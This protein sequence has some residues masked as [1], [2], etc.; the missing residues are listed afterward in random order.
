MKNEA[1]GPRY[2]GASRWGEWLSHTHIL[3]LI[4]VYLLFRG[5]PSGSDGKESACNL[6]DLDLIP[7]SGRSPGEGNGYPLQY[8]CWRIPWTEEPG[9]L[10]SIEWQGVGHDYMTN[11]FGFTYFCQDDWKNSKWW[12]L[13]LP[14]S[15]SDHYEQSSPA[16]LWKHVA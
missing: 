6:G 3:F 11:T 15:L 5:F 14:P 10:Q 2:S 16:D 13:C 8:S 4:W 7:G 1:R 12:L 9:R